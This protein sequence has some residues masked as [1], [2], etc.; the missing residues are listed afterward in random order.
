MSTSSLECSDSFAALSSAA[1][2]MT[3][4]SAAAAGETVKEFVV[5]PV[6]E[7]SMDK[8]SVKQRGRDGDAPFFYASYDHRQ[9]VL[10]LTNN[11]WF[12]IAY[13]I[14]SVGEKLDE[15]T[16]SLNVTVAVD[17]GVAAAIQKV[18]SAIK[19]H[20]L[21]VIP[22]V[23]WKDSIRPMEH[24]DPLFRTKLVVKAANEAQ[25]SVCTIR[26][27]GKAPMRGI[28]GDALTPLLK[29][30]RGFVEANVKLGVALFKVWTMKDKQ[31]GEILAGATWRITNLMADLAEN[32]KMTYPDIF[33]DEDFPEQ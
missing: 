8:F 10:N 28:V 33:A 19:E 16:Q 30:N 13:S 31:T 11:K 15:K 27:F 20:V 17:T 2:A 23:Q 5:T 18:E 7:I 29:T 3:K 32:V 24:Y 26:E 14:D 25:L 1:E 4:R 22:K 6:E 21:A 12:R 9:L